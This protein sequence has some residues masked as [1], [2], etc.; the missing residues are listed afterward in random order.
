[1]N[2]YKLK[3]RL[4]LGRTPV[5]KLGGY[6]GGPEHRSLEHAVSFVE[7]AFGSK[8]YLVG[9]ATKSPD[10]RDVDVRMIL[11]DEEFHGLFGRGGGTSPFWSLLTVAISEYLERRTGLRVDFQVQCRGKNDQE[12]FYCSARVRESDWDKWREPLALY[13][14][15]EGFLPGWRKHGTE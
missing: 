13:P 9:S 4:G 11:D 8:L 12:H 5:S 6:L 14:V 3:R 1:M 2:L 7:E 15:N 10:F